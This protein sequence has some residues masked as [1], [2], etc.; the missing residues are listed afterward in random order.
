M[1]QRAGIAA[2]GAH[3]PCLIVADEPTSA[4]DAERADATLAA[5]RSTGAAVLLVSH[6]IRLVGRHADRLAVCHAG[7]VV[8][9]D[10]AEAVLE[11]PRHPYTVALLSAM[12]RAGDTLSIPVD[13][14]AETVL[15]ARSVSHA[16]GHGE[17]TVRAVIR[18]DL[19]VRRGEILGIYGD[20]GCGKST[21]LRVLARIEPPTTGTIS[22]GD[23][24][25]TTSQTKQ[26]FDARARRGFVM[27]IFQDP[28]GSLDR[29][30]AVWR[31][32]TEPLMAKHRRPRLSQ[33][34]RREIARERLAQVGLTQ[35]DL[36]AR[37][38]EL[39]VGQCQRISIARALVAEPALIVADEPTSA[40]DATSAATILRL[41]AAASE[42][43]IAIIIVSHDGVIL[44][45]LCHR[46]LR[47]RDGVLEEE[48]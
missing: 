36:E 28:A 38:D 8:E 2:A 5:L 48:M 18:A 24:P 10:E 30:W 23:E 41:L 15:E 29:R 40:L 25:A 37:P 26:S 42:Q 7:R 47:M 9:I 32:V 44:R 14:R 43:G 12:P 21:L 19:S 4:L 1:L 31:I 11:R 16:Y 45:A 17:E 27:P 46:V 22:W 3:Q 20:S 33:R 39:S 6:D 34:E 35:I 13:A